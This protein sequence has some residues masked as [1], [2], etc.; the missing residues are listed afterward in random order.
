M[1]YIDIH[2]YIVVF[3][4]CLYTSVT[5]HHLRVEYASLLQVFDQPLNRFLKSAFLGSLYCWLALYTGL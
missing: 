1:T 4:G 5:G 3:G 2:I